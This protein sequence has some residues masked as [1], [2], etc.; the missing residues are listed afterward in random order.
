MSETFTVWIT[1]YAMSS[2]IVCCTA[3]PSLTGSG[4]IHVRVRNV[5]DSYF[6]GEGREW[7]RTRQAAI[8]R[9]ET[10]RTEKLAS[11]EKQA[12]KIRKLDFSTAPSEPTP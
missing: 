6:H 12:A 1:K 3:T 2:D 8:A 5:L 11:L 7:H 4:T 9:A 10:M